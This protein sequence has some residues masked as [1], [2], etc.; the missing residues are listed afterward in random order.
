MFPKGD[1]P[2]KS[3]A[4][5]LGVDSVPLLMFTEAGK[6]WFKPV[7]SYT[8][9][10]VGMCMLCQ[11]LKPKVVLEIGTFYG[12]GA[13]HWAA[14]AP[15]AQIY[16]LD[17]ADESTPSLGLTTMDKRYVSEHASR[18]KM[19]FD[20]RP[21][22]DRITCLY[23]DSATFDFTPYK[24]KV[25]LLFIDGA[26][27]YDYVKSDTLRTVE[28]CKPG[29]VVA[30]HDYGRTGFNGVSRFLHEYATDS[31]KIYRIPGGSL[32]FMVVS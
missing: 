29:T 25:D 7:G 2:Q 16:T 22:A 27:S 12:S 9:D 4:E 8:A 18:K 11:I 14:N 5:V 6:E 17:L 3:V 28:C 13:L 32:A 24:G 23:G 26:H 31:R 20:G 21:E 15:D 1:L 30:W 10:L 19:Q